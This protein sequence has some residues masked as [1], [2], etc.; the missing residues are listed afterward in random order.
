MIY[1]AILIW[2][3]IAF[4]ETLH[5]IARVAFLNRRIGDRRARQIS[6]LTG[7]AI[8]LIIAWFAIP[9]I[10]VATVG[11]CLQ[12]GLLWLSLMLAFDLLLGRLYFRLSWRRLLADFNPRRGGFLGLGMLV[13]LL[14]PLIV[15]RFRLM[16]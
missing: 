12:I 14:A 7:S 15:A 4:A 6:V 5:G 16:L 10:G 1:K 3:L 9:W 2:V 8:I 11:R 13:L